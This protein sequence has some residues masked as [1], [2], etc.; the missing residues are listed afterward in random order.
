MTAKAKLPA[1]RKVAAPAKRRH[2]ATGR[3]RGGQPK[4]TD[5]HKDEIINRL[6]DGQNLREVCRME[7]MPNWATVYRWVEDDEAFMQRFMRARVLGFDAIAYDSKTIAATPM[8]GERRKTWTQKVDGEL[9]E[10]VEVWTEEMLGHRKLMV[11]TNLKLLSKWDPKRY[12]ERLG[13]TD[14]NGDALTITLS[15]PDQSVV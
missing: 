6:A 8:M 10:M 9:V 12:G 4:F 3:P 15:V 7:G 5:T 14:G 2:V 13:L 11:E 1:K